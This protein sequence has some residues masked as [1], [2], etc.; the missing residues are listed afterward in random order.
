MKRVSLA[1]LFVAA[2]SQH[3]SPAP[4]ESPQYRDDV[5]VQKDVTWT[6]LVNATATGSAITKS[7]GQPQVDDAGGVSTEA[8]G[9]GDG[10][11]D[12]TVGDPAAFCFEGLERAHADTTG[13][14]IDFA[15]RVQGGRADVY[16]LGV[17]GADNT[18]A[19]GDTLRSA[20]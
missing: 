11:L 2:C 18:V 17:W 15:F 12:V 7:G 5:V 1:I 6:Q 13:N 8:I 9:S 20:V 4:A 16:E 10:W 3:G 19:A 14:A